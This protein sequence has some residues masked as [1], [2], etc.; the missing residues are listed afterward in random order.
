ML[1]N[2]IQSTEKTVYYQKQKGRYIPVSEYDPCWLDSRAYGTYITHVER[3]VSS[4]QRAVDPDFLALE[5]AA[6]VLKDQL[7]AIVLAANELRPSTTP[8]TERQ[9]ELW[10]QLVDTGFTTVYYPSAYQVAEQFL[11]AIVNQAK[12]TVSENACVRD[13][14]EQ[15][16]MALALTKPQDSQDK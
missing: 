4:T 6:L 12:Q 16:Q 1:V 14:Q 10:Q 2:K 9:R 3:G 5:A 11:Q 15:Y 13:L 7:P 8:I